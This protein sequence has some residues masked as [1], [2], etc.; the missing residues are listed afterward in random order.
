MHE[1]PASSL[2]GSKA[3]QQ[4]PAWQQIVFQVFCLR[5]VSLDG[6]RMIRSCL[7]LVAIA[8]DGSTG[9]DVQDK[10]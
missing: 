10:L 5:D 7:D 6:K 3:V 2:L 8:I 4:H 1:M 9:S